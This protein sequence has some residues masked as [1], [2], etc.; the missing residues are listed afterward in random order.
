MSDSANEGEAMWA[1]TESE[2]RLPEQQ[3]ETV[4]RLLAGGRKDG[5]FELLPD[6]LV[7]V[8]VRGDNI[9]YYVRQDGSIHSRQYR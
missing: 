1:D 8:I 9:D 4:D 7:R 3:A 6:N 5:Y 2:G